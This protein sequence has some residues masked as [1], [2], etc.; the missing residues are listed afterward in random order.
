MANFQYARLL[1]VW[2]GY[3]TDTKPT[4]IDRDTLAYEYDT[5]NT[6]IWTGTEWK[7]I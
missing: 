5:T 7:V 4:N 6:Y 3:S 2:T 1:G